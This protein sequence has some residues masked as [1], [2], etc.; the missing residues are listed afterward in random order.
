M[1]MDEYYRGLYY[2]PRWR[3]FD[4]GRSRDLYLTVSIVTNE[5]AGGQYFLMLPR[6]ERPD[7]SLQLPV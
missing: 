3:G 2:Y 4:A 5:V 1:E 6:K 7:E